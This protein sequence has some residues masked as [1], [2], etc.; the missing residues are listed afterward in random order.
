MKG[1]ILD[2]I[3]FLEKERNNRRLLKTVRQCFASGFP[4]AVL[5]SKTQGEKE[6][7]AYWNS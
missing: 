4:A 1:K 3:R 6:H 7:L 2:L 5:R